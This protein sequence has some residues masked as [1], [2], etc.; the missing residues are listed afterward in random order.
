MGNQV[1]GAYRAINPELGTLMVLEV[2]EYAPA[3]EVPQAA[4]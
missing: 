2:L 3:Q 1:N 4:E